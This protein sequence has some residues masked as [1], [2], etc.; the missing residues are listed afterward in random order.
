MALNKQAQM[1]YELGQKNLQKRVAAYM[2]ERAAAQAASEAVAA[3][4][5]SGQI[6]NAVAA[7]AAAAAPSMLGEMASVAP[8]AGRLLGLG[9]LLSMPVNAALRYG[10]THEAGQQE[11][12]S[13][14]DLATQQAG[15]SP[16]VATQ[17]E[18]ARKTRLQ[19]QQAAA[20]Q[21]VQYGQTPS[22]PYGQTPEVSNQYQ[23]GRENLLAQIANNPTNAGMQQ[24]VQQMNLEKGI[25][26]DPTHATPANL[27]SQPVQPM[28]TGMQVSPELMRLKLKEYLASPEFKASP[29]MLN[30]VMIDTTRK[31]EQLYGSDERAKLQHRLAE[32]KTLRK[33]GMTPEDAGV[34]AEQGPKALTYFDMKSTAQKNLDAAEAYKIEYLKLATQKPED[35]MGANA[36]KLASKFA[37]VT[38]AANTK[39]NDKGMFSGM[40]SFFGYD[41]ETDPAVITQ[42]LMVNPEFLRMVRSASGPLTPAPT[43]INPAAGNLINAGR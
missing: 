28:Q 41:K 38:A 14:Q 18:L 10:I 43:Q 7:R 27:T 1:A 19:P 42:E 17:I 24:L 26:N 25:Y 39:A 35:A 33:Y 11:A 9:G 29:D 20:A 34:W 23:A 30:S 22:V 13:E 31:I 8:A 3:R 16:E 2:A 37:T 5:A 36:L 6:V 12:Q 15:M 40:R 21:P 32:V 4:V